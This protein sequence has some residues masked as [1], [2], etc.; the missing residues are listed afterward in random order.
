MGFQIAHL[1][2]EVVER[3]EQVGI[4]LAGGRVPIRWY[5]RIGTGMLRG[6][7]TIRGAGAAAKRPTPGGRAMSEVCGEGLRRRAGDGEALA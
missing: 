1:R 7:A 4:G 2:H 6:P 5:M 3:H